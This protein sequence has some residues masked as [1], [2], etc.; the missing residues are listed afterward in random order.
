MT[1][2]LTLSTSALALSCAA[3]LTTAQTAE[4]TWDDIINDHDTNDDVLMYGLG[5]SAQRY[6]SLEQINAENVEHLRPAWAFSFG[7]EKQRARKPKP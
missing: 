3:G 6:S 4:V 2:L 1:R 5:N 7:D